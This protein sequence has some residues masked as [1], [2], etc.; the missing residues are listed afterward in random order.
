MPTNFPTSVDALTNPISND[1]LNS[2]SHSLQHANANDAIEAIETYLLNGGQGLT[3]VKKQTVG[4]AVSS[5]V[6]TGAFSAT[7]EHYKIIYSGGTASTS[8]ALSIQLSGASTNYQYVGT[9]Q[10]FGNSTVI[11]IVGGPISTWD[12][13]GRISANGNQLNIDLFSPFLTTTTPFTSR[14]SDYITNG[15]VINN[16]GLHN[17]SVSH[18]GFTIIPASGTLTG[19]VIY[20]YGYGIGQ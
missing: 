13:V 6:V 1:S 11:G 18:T 19:G 4:S 14:C 16:A 20:V 3:L 17:A 15:F 5:V 8:A 9:A 7:Y 10:Q 2:P 12:N